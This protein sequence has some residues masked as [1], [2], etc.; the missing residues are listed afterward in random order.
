MYKKNAKAAN[1]LVFPFA[2]TG[3][4]RDF[5]PFL[6][7]YLPGKVNYMVLSTEKIG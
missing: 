7:A 5:R 2:Q 1:R 3:K 4:F 6:D